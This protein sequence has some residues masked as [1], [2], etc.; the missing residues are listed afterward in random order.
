VL[1]VQIHEVFGLEAARA[2]ATVL[3]LPWL[4]FESLHAKFRRTR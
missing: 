1:T 4:G 3:V 2:L